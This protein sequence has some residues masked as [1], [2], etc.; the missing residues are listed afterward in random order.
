MVHPS[1]DPVVPK[2]YIM[3]MESTTSWDQGFNL[4]TGQE[5]GTA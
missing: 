2:P 4:Y 3:E 5:E 1:S